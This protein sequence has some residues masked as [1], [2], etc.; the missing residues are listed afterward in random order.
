ML[1]QI[2]ED[3]ERADDAAELIGKLTAIRQWLHGVSDATYLASDVPDLHE[4]DV[5]TP[6][7]TM[8]FYSSYPFA[9]DPYYIGR[10]YLEQLKENGSWSTA[11]LWNPDRMKDGFDSGVMIM[12]L[13]V[14]DELVKRAKSGVD[15]VLERLELNSCKV[16]VLINAGILNIGALQAQVVGQ[17][18]D[19]LLERVPPL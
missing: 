17:L 14:A 18:A 15:A 11:P 4:I 19:A 1:L 2:V 9:N 10:Y 5:S 13:K 12:K 7:S 16:S 6:V 8:P 3:E